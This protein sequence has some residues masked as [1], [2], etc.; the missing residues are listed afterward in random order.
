M[1]FILFCVKVPVLSEQIIETHPKL[2]TAFNCLIIAFSLTIFWVEIEST[3]V[4]IDPKASGIAATAK[5][6]AIN[7]ASNTFSC[8]KKTLMAK[9]MAQITQ[10]LMVSLTENSSKLFCNGV[11]RSWAFSIMLAI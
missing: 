5:A 4:T 11:L 7:K 8:A 10:M 9:I 3:I 6:T 1:T 2:S